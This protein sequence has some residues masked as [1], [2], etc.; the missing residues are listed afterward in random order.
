[1]G[2]FG[3][4]AILNP[5]LDSLGVQ[6]SD[7]KL[8][9]QSDQYAPDFIMAGFSNRSELAL[10]GVGVL[11]QKKAFVTLPGAVGLEY[12]DSP[13]RA[14][15]VIVTDEKN[16]WSRPRRAVADTAAAV[17][18][19]VKGDK[20]GSVPL[21]LALTRWR[22]G[23]QQRIMVVGNADFLTEKELE[24]QSNAQSADFEFATRVFQWLTYGQYPPDTSH[25]D[26]YGQ[27]NAGKR[28]VLVARIFFL[29]ILPGMMVLWATVLL[30][31]R[32]RR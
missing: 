5:L 20:K 4:Q 11:Y 30:W 9:Q 14:L 19:P 1:V 2:Q 6:F 17:Y 24:G 12:G 18:T 10:P 3:R 23:R 29:G 22:E 28:G 21:A 15:P 32:A 31:R 25:P 26:I 8:L 16:T 7:G 27:V 13:F